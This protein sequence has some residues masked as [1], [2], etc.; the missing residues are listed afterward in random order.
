MKQRTLHLFYNHSASYEAQRFGLVVSKTKEIQ[1]KCCRI[2][3]S[4]Q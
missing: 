1:F 2:Y 3:G 4:V